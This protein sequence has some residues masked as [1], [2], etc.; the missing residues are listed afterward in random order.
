MMIWL[1]TRFENTV[2]N[3]SLF[4]CWHLRVIL[5][6]AKLVLFVTV[7]EF[8]AQSFIFPLI[9]QISI[10]KGPREGCPR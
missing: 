9:V 4:I 3:M 5:Y 7:Q 8:S 2:P 6:V 10:T 1:Y